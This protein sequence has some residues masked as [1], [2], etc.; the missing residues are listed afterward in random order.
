MQLT[1]Q[2]KLV[3][4]LLIMLVCA[5]STVH[6]QNATKLSVN[7]QELVFKNHNWFLLDVNTT[8][9][10]FYKIDTTTITIR[11]VDSISYEDKLN[12]ETTN[13]LNLIDSFSTYYKYKFINNFA[14]FKNNIESLKN[15]VKVDMLVIS[16]LG[17]LNSNDPLFNNQKYLFADFFDIESIRAYWGY[18]NPNVTVAVV[19]G[20]VDWS[21]PDLGTSNSTYQNIWLNNREDAWAN[22]NDPSTGNGIDDDHNG[23]IDDW[24]GYDFYYDDNDVRPEPNFPNNYHGTI[25]SSIIAAK[26]NNGTG[27]SGFAGGNNN[28]GVKVMCLNVAQN[29]TS[30]GVIPNI[31]KTALARAIVYAAHNGA[32]IICLTAA[33]SPNTIAP[34]IDEAINIAINKYDCVVLCASGNGQGSN[35]S[36]FYPA[37]IKD[38]LA[39]GAFTLIGN[40]NTQ[41]VNHYTSGPELDYVAYAMEAEDQSY[42]AK[43]N[44]TYGYLSGGGTSV[45][46][47]QIAGFLA[48]V[49]SKYECIPPSILLDF[50]KNSTKYKGSA[51]LINNR[52]DL[53]GY[54]MPD[55]IALEGAFNNLFFD[56]NLT[57]TTTTISDTRYC[58]TDID[59][60]AGKT[61]TITG[62][63]IMANGK[64]IFVRPQG[65][66]IVDNGGIITSNCEWG[67][68][69]VYGDGDPL[70]PQNDDY[71]GLT[72]VINNSLIENAKC[73]IKTFG[74]GKVIANGGKF[75]NNYISIYITPMY[76][77][78]TSGNIPISYSEIKN[79]RFVFDKNLKNT[80]YN[81]G[82][83]R[84]GYNSFIKIEDSKYLVLENNYFNDVLK[85]Y[86]GTAIN[87]YKTELYIHN[88]TFYNVFNAIEIFKI[89]TYYSNNSLKDNQILYNTFRDVKKGIFVSSIK[90]PQIWGNSIFLSRAFN[91]YSPEGY[92]EYNWGVFTANSV[93]EIRDNTFYSPDQNG[94]GTITNNSMMY[95]ITNDQIKKNT[96]NN[97]AVG[98]QFEFNYKNLKATCNSYTNIRDYAWS[99]SP[100]RDDKSSYFPNVGDKNQEVGG[101]IFFDM[102]N[103]NPERHIKSRRAFK[104]Y[105]A[106]FPSTARPLFNT[107]IV[108]TVLRQGIYNDAYCAT[109]KPGRDTLFCNGN[110]CTLA[111]LVEMFEQ[112][113]DTNIQEELFDQ[114]YAT[115]IENENIYGFLSFIESHNL[116]NTKIK[117]VISTYIDLGDFTTAEGLMYILPLTTTQDSDFY[118]LIT[119][120]K[121]IKVENRSISNLTSDEKS[122]FLNIKLHDNEVSLIAAQILKFGYGIPYNQNPSQWEEAVG[123]RTE[124]ATIA[125]KKITSETK[126]SVFPN[127]STKEGIL[128]VCISNNQKINRIE[129]YNALGERVNSYT[130]HDQSLVSID[131]SKFNSGIY[132]ILV[133]TKDSKYTNKYVKL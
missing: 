116:L 88:N 2:R 14:R 71:D 78:L 123:N 112:E 76:N 90:S 28:E 87:V 24:K 127:P 129:V 3:L 12:F 65:K 52:S 82:D 91:K 41:M 111:E 130:I 85:S 18:G 17:K 39:I 43:P 79:N 118:N 97:L 25:V 59:I 53:F 5:L 35:N 67:G 121:N 86:E 21:H 27:A 51:A 48:L 74:E 6:A 61:L 110:L 45:A 96:F 23:L 64:K 57:T 69:E 93:S 106:E 33:F 84:K 126:V 15:S 58:Q 109:Q 46:T 36:V 30:T 19:D 108:N 113:I 80:T 103:T 132:T 101:N 92:L 72:K 38:V 128:N 81:N 4:L 34:M 124:V 37:K 63:L 68:I 75:N 8:D 42:A 47:A 13:S 100:R 102:I 83:I 125:P 10:S 50:L 9:S 120:Y 104:Y 54:G 122:L 89:Y 1:L 7:N 44:N 99:I 119:V 40:N 70:T 62:K 49:L 20:F 56:A 60:P 32:K 95:N 26:T 16:D 77:N 98:S 29:N 107:T 73:G 115:Y 133:F 22:P 66:L 117:E 55:P 31:D 11:Y 131:F 105:Y 94:Y 114:I